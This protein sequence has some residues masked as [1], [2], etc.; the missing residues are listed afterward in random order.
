MSEIVTLLEGVSAGN[1]ILMMVLVIIYALAQRITIKQI[2][3]LLVSG[4][5]EFKQKFE[6][7]VVTSS[8]VNDLLD[9]I[10]RDLNA[11]R[12]YVFQYHNGGK[13]INGI[14]FARCSNTHE[15]CEVGIESNIQAYQNLPLAMY[16]LRNDLIAKNETIV[17]EDLDDI[18]D[19]DKTAYNIMKQQGIKSLYTVGLY[20][21][22]CRPMGFLGVDFTRDKKILSEDDLNVLRTM[23]HVISGCINKG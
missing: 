10:L 12:V 15:R 1:F 3:E 16:G 17:V 18:I 19:T 23:A 7:T 14:P 22:T 20:T 2:K 13:N 4:E 5:K 11:D 21:D 6:A 9:Q 8:V